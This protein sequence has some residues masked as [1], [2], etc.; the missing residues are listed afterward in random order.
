MFI[1]QEPFSLWDNPWFSIR[2]QVTLDVCVEEGGGDLDVA[3][4]GAALSG[5]A[6]LGQ[7]DPG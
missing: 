4:V 3:L 7:L 2:P 6:G 1:L 5:S